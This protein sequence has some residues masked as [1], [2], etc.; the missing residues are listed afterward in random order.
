MDSAITGGERI[1]YA[2]GL[3]T[4]LNNGSW[5]HAATT[6]DG[7][8]RRIY[9][10]GVQVAQDTPGSN[11]AT[12]ANFR[13][14]STNN[15]EF[16]NG[17]IDDVA[18]YNHALTATEIQSL[19]SGG[20]PLAG[21]I[22][23]SFTA[24]PAS[25]YEGGAVTLNWNVNT[26]NVT[27]VFSYEIKYGNITVTSG[28]AASG[29]FNT[30]VPDLAGTAQTVTWTFRAIETGGN[31]VTNTAGAGIAG[32]PGIPSATSQAGLTTSGG[33]PLPV[34]LAGSDPNGGALS[35]LIV[36]PPAKGTL[37]RNEGLPHLYGHS[38]NVWRGSIHVQGKRRQYSVRRGHRAAYHPHPA[39][40][41]VLRHSR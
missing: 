40:R 36:S 10:N 13:I 25:A 41:S 38:R 11:G 30:T 3:S 6:Y 1:S 21:P 24:A 26:A 20:S 33:T 9:L 39:H 28:S 22:I 15:G 34:T 14:G 2:T 23:T 32:D 8:T 17:T 16:F 19:A 5:H 31:N 29:T 7:T 18:I 4:V 35:Y 27:G 12:A 37:S